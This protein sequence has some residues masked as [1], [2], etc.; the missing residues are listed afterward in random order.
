MSRIYI[1]EKNF[2]SGINIIQLNIIY[3]VDNFF[4][5]LIALQLL[6]PFSRFYFARYFNSFFFHLHG[7]I[8]LP[9]VVL[10]VVLFHI[11]CICHWYNSQS[12]S[13]KSYRRS[14]Q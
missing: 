7:P 12:C 3:I 11:H 2:C 10:S 13:N 4:L 5:I 8:L 9:C 14:R 1:L 6:F